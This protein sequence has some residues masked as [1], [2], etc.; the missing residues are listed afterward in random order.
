MRITGGAW[1]GRRLVAPRGNSVRPT[2]DRVRESVFQILAPRLAGAAVLDVCAGTGALGLEALSR[3]AD[4]AVFIERH[5]VAL[6]ALRQNIE[7]LVEAEHSRAQVHSGDAR[8]ELASL[9]RAASRYALVFMDPP[10]AVD[11]RDAAVTQ[12]IQLLE[13]QGLLVLECPATD[14]VTVPTARCVDRRLY[15]QTSVVFLEAAAED[16]DPA[17]RGSGVAP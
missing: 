10:Y 11:W 15:G 6:K 12:A 14:T 3:G 13:P 1:R 5:P 4:S 8:Q 16:A 7:A 17:A 9:R 2:A